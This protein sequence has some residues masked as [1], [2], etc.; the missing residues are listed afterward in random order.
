[1][2]LLVGFVS[3]EELGSMRAHIVV[4]E[5]LLTEVD[6]VAGKRKRSHFVEEAIREKLSRAK[7]SAALQQSAGVLAAADYPEW[8][9]PEQV[10]AWVSEGRSADFPRLARKLGAATD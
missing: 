6:Q 2:C 5:E 7:R 8:E 10:S 3:E 4:S 1:M 9:A